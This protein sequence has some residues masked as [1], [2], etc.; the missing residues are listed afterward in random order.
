MRKA[1]GKDAPEADADV[2]PAYYAMLK[3]KEKAKTPEPV[4]GPSIEPEI[5]SH[6]AP[7]TAPLIDV[8]SK[9]FATV[10]APIVELVST[11]IWTY[12]GSGDEPPYMINFMSKQRFVR[13]DPVEVTDPDLISTWQIAKPPRD[14]KPESELS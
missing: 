8:E 10:T 3:K 9:T 13:G 6:V 1:L 14:L 12:I 2:M 11:N 7:A 4:V 5:D